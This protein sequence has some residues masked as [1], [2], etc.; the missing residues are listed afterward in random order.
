[1]QTPVAAPHLRLPLATE[2][3]NPEDPRKVLVKPSPGEGGKETWISENY[4]CDMPPPD[5]PKDQGAK[6]EV[7]GK[8]CMG[9]PASCPMV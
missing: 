7:V 1:M 5:F 2:I 9:F 3:F 4:L 6:V 8:K